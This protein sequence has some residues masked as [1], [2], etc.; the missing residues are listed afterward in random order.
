MA[1]AV[2]PILQVGGMQ[3]FRVEAFETDKVLPRAAQIENVA[4]VVYNGVELLDFA[5]PGEVFSAAFEG[6]QALFEVFTVADRAKPITSTSLASGR[7][8]RGK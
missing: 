5:G 6:G 1:V 8:M 7:S 2:L 3:M 4:I